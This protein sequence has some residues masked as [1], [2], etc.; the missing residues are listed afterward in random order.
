MAEDLSGTEL[1]GDEPTDESVAGVNPATVHFAQRPPIR[2]SAR[3]ATYNGAKTGGRRVIEYDQ[4]PKEAPRLRVM[5]YDKLEK[6]C[7]DEVEFYEENP[8][9]L[10][11]VWRRI[12][13]ANSDNNALKVKSE[14]KSGLFRPIEGDPYVWFVVQVKREIW[15]ALTFA[16]TSDMDSEQKRF[17]LAYYRRLGRQTTFQ[18]KLILELESEVYDDP[19]RPTETTRPPLSTARS[20]D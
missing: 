17:V 12:W 6:A 20:E 3:W 19:R 4:L 14:M 1:D 8:E 15:V 16:D 10:G 13:V 5:S 7:E 11:R 9:K 2:S 18:K